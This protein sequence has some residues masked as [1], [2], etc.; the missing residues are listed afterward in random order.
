MMSF[1]N[2]YLDKIPL[3]HSILN[4][5]SQIQEYKG[6]QD[7]YKQQTPEILDSLKQVAI[8]QS[9]ESS[10][11]IEG[12]YAT[13]K[14]IAEL[15]KLKASPQNR[16]EAEIAGYRDV[17]ETIHSSA[18]HIRISTNTILQ[19]HR[20]L[21]KLATGVGGRWKQVDNSIKEI[22][23]TGEQIIRFEPTLAWKT[24]EA[25]EELV[26][27]FRMEREQKNIHDL[28]VIAAFILDFLCI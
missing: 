17:L 24:P 25:M 5:L 22:L 11:R 28:I 21:L 20:D 9:T 27:A 12:I 3:N 6:K 14:R 1:R 16:S 19:L 4:L 15:V 2:S 18:E 10:N 23:P 13:D 7:L 8:I 26:Q